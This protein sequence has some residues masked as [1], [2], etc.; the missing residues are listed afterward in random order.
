MYMLQRQKQLY[1]NN[2]NYGSIKKNRQ[3]YI[4]TNP[5]YS[6]SPKNKVLKSPKRTIHTTAQNLM[7]KISSTQKRGSVRCSPKASESRNSSRNGVGIFRSINRKSKRQNSFGTYSNMD[8]K[9][10]QKMNFGSATKSP[11][12]LASGGKKM[13][14]K[15]SKIQESLANKIAYGL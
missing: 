9:S 15:K 12:K 10:S 4:N 1:L 5:C 7:A 11:G 8:S 13:K 3:S 2:S 14:K 6:K